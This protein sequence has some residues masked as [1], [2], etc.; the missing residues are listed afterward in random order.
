MSSEQPARS[1]FERLIAR[2]AAG[3]DEA[4]WELLAR[5][6]SNIRR[7][8]RRTLPQEIRG[9]MD[10]ADVVQSVWTSL[11]R[12]PGKLGE[13]REVEQFIAYLVGMARLKVFEAHRR[14]TRVTGRNV[15]REIPIDANNAEEMK[16]GWRSADRLEVPDHA[17]NTP[18]EIVAASES[19]NRALA[20]EG[21]RGRK[22][23]ELRLTGL[24]H[25]QIAERLKIGESSVR[26]ILSSM[27]QSLTP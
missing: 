21:E 11:L 12:D 2:I 13:I 15:R 1:E 19:W 14:Y 3:S 10:S 7:V 23:V 5:Y 16:T 26:R 24:T 9:K 27:L 17:A 4:V 8:V 22:I 20:R 18:S 6:S 25:G